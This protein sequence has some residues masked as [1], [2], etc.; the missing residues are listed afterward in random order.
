MIFLASY[1]SFLLAT[2]FNRFPIENIARASLGGVFV[3]VD[4]FPLDPWRQWTVGDEI[5]NYG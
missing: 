1:R 5:E 3:L 4:E 2:F